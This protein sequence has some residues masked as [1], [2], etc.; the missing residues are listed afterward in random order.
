MED[1]FYGDTISVELAIQREL[2]YRRKLALH[3]NPNDDFLKDLIPLEVIFFLFF[4]LSLFLFVV[5]IFL[6][7]LLMIKFPWFVLSV[8]IH[9]S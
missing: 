4:F 7:Q 2:A 1:E 8:R 6:T 3:L 5:S 9:N